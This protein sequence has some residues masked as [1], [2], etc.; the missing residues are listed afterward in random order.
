[1]YANAL[2]VVSNITML[3]RF[4]LPEVLEGLGSLSWYFVPHQKANASVFFVLHP[5]H[6]II[7]KS[8]N[9]SKRV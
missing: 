1:M 9:N 3:T 6:H 5:L 7:A 4:S 2:A 8:G